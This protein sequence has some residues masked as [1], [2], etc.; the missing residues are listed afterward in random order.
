M[1]HRG[2]AL[3]RQEMNEEAGK[4]ASVGEGNEGMTNISNVSPR[5]LTAT[6]Q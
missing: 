4:K 5:Q 3:H 1:I 6:Y 2:H